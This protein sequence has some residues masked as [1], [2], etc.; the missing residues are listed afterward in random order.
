M[1]TTDQRVRIT[2]LLIRKAFCELLKGK[3]LQKISIKELCTLAGINRGT[4]YTHYQDIYDLLDQ[5]EQEM[6]DDF[7]L[8]LEPILA[9][10]QKKSDL[11][12]ICTGVFQFLKENY[13]MCVIM[14]GENGDRQFVSRL[15]SLGRK[16]CI[17]SYSK[18]F[19]AASEEQL[20]YY[21]S[22]VSSGCIGLLTPWVEEGMRTPA[23]QI[24]QM[25][26]EIM[27]SGIGFLEKPLL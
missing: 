25:A 13:D 3:P 16:E 10:D 21:Y 22:F 9:D 19:P 6:I 2:K 4:F 14:L 26:G 5:M 11:V 18:H 20:E 12:E 15:L 1:K 24:A 8:A 23:E 27:F 17:S 7:I